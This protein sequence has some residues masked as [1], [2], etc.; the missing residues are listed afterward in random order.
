MST[1]ELD[2]FFV[3]DVTP[4]GGALL[5]DANNDDQ[6]TGGDL[7]SVQQNFG[8]VYPSDPS[9]DGMGL[10]DANDDCLVTGGDLISVQQNFGKVANSAAVPEPSTL[11]LLGLGGAALVAR[12]RG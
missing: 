12:R 2:H 10:G 4:I 1:A 7:I 6:V 11:A 3:L 9:C 5:G 8:K